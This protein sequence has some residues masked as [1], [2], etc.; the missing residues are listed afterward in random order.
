MGRRKKKKVKQ[1][2]EVN[3]RRVIRSD[4]VFKDAPR[5]LSYLEEKYVRNKRAQICLY[6]SLKQIP[7]DFALMTYPYLLNKTI[8]NGTKL[9]FS[10]SLLVVDEAHN[11]EGAAGFSYIIST[12]GIEKAG[13]EFLS[14]CLPKIRG[15]DA[16]NLGLALSRLS[17][18]IHLHRFRYSN[19]R[20]SLS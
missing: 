1:I 20:R 4:A 9:D 5:G 13:K 2:V 7:S 6:Q 3:A 18:L 17:K 14:K 10:K 12:G 16:K 15:F 19:S 11:L 8:R